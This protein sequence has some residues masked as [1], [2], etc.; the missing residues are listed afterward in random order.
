MR[1]LGLWETSS[2]QH[3]FRLR[4]LVYYLW[5]NRGLICETIFVTT[6]SI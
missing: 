1:L 5:R 6:W 4:V 2:R 3:F